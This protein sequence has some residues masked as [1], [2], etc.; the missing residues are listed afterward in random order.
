MSVSRPSEPGEPRR[1][2]EPEPKPAERM[3]IHCCLGSFFISTWMF[4]SPFVCLYLSLSRPFSHP[5]ASRRTGPWSWQQHQ[6]LS[7]QTHHRIFYRNRFAEGPVGKHAVEH[8]GDV[9]KTTTPTTGATCKDSTSSCRHTRSS[10]ESRPA[11]P[12]PTPVEVSPMR[13]VGWGYAANAYDC[14]TG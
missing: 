1:C 10:S 2:P 8:A 11:R 13:W 9:D 5:P 7:T 3:S 14:E 6:C 4:F 12:T